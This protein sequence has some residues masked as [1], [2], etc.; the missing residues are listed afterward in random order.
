MIRPLELFIGLRYT[1]AR[2]SNHFISFIS[3]MAAIG[4][5]LGVT[6]LITVLSVMNGFGNDLRSRMLGAV[7][8]VTVTADRG[9]LRDWSAVLDQA[10]SMQGVEGAAPYVEGQGMLVSDSSSRGA[11]V[12]GIDPVAET[13]VARFQQKMT[14]GSLDNL[15]PGEYGIIIG[16]EIAWRLGLEMGSS[17]SVLSSRAQ[18]TPAGI[19]PRYKRFH[20]VGIFEMGIS[21]YDGSLALIHIDDARRLY[22]TGTGV[23]GIRMQLADLFFAPAMAAEL[24]SKL[25]DHYVVNDWTRENASFFRALRIEKTAMFIIMML[26]IAVAAFNIV[27]MLVMLVTDKEGDIAILRTVGMSP[28]SVMGV[29]MIHGA[30]LGV[31]GT[32]AGA[33]AG[34]LLTLN[35]DSVVRFFESVFQAQLFTADIYYNTALNPELRWADVTVITISSLLL[36]IS[37]TLYPA[38]RAA[39]INPAQA[40]HYE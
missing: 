32:I 3:L 11:M 19:L 20:V 31:F 23:T 26:A 18:I 40:L 28:G 36:T 4:I 25:G 27:S 35:I 7:S 38:R 21:D 2:R 16:S 8:H 37:A 6:A 29:F 13:R 12:R 24:Q 22:Q 17:V 15:K 14:S 30:I 9:A 34:V 39:S 5:V 10:N 33:S 1:R